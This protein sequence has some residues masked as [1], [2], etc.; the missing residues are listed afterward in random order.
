MTQNVTYFDTYQVTMS[1]IDFY[2]KICNILLQLHY[3][4][5]ESLSSNTYQVTLSRRKLLSS[6]LLPRNTLLKHFP[7]GEKDKR[8]SRDIP[9]AFSRR[10]K[11]S[12]DISKHFC[13][14][15]YKRSRSK[16]NLLTL[17]R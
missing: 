3:I 4:I 11:Q 1:Y 13:Q 2:V 7:E 5:K 6:Q 16:C 9:Y 12:R 15:Q 14:L 8:H 10:K 17:G